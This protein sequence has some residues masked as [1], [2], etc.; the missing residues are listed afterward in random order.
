MIELSPLALN[1]LERALCAAERDRASEV[2]VSTET[3]RS[4]VDAKRSADVKAELEEEIE[5]LE[6]VIEDLRD[7]VRDLKDEIG[8]AAEC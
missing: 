5:H 7:E 1:A 6:D 2:T 3:L 4:V 8:E